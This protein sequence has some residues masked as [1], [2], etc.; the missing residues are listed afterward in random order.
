MQSDPKGTELVCQ[1][2]QRAFESRVQLIDAPIDVQLI[3]NS[4]IELIEA[5]I[6]P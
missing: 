4:C 2:I 1:L 6:I 5:I 3:S